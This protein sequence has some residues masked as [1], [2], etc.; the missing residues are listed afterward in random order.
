MNTKSTCG[1]TVT[2]NVSFPSSTF[3]TVN[4]RFICSGAKWTANTS[5]KYLVQDTWSETNAPCFCTHLSNHVVGVAKVEG[6]RP[7]EVAAL[8]L[9]IAHLLRG[10]GRQED[11]HLCLQ[12]DDRRFLGSEEQVARVRAIPSEDLPPVVHAKYLLRFKNVPLSGDAELLAMF[13]G[14]TRVC[15]QRAC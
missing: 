3:E 10:V 2:P 6:A 1:N 12:L 9:E 14:S 11:I 8:D 4:W 7:V 15:W 5:T 13:D